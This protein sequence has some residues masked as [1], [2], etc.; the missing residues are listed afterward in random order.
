MYLCHMGNRAEESRQVLILFYSHACPCDIPACSHAGL[1]RTRASPCRHCQSAK[2]SMRT[3]PPAGQSLVA[4]TAAC[5][6]TNSNSAPRLSRP[7]QHMERTPAKEHVRQ[8]QASDGS[9]CCREPDACERHISL[10]RRL[11]QKFSPV[12]SDHPA[13]GRPAHVSASECY[14]QGI[15]D[16]F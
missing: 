8:A 16:S 3:S 1:M 11:L 6:S 7:S 15:Q 9:R 4:A 14:I 12:E 13:L 2:V 10:C 5:N